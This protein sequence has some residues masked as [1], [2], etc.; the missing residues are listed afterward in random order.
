MH[1]HT[2]I[3]LENCLVDDKVNKSGFYMPPLHK[4]KCYF[5]REYVSQKGLNKHIE[6]CKEMHNN[7]KFKCD[8]CPKVYK[9]ENGFKRHKEKCE[10]LRRCPKCFKIF[11]NAITYHDHIA[12]EKCVPLTERCW[13]C[14]EY[15]THTHYPKHYS[16]CTLDCNKC[17]RLVKDYENLTVKEHLEHNTN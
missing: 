3:E 6:K 5:C 9:T 12:Q 1:A 16:T 11:I 15:F 14:Q 7:A 8:S 13:K 17:G 2:A 10:K 4:A